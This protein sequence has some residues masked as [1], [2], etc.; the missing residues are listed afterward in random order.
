MVWYSVA[1]TEQKKI[2]GPAFIKEVGERGHTSD[3][4]GGSSR[5]KAEAPNLDMWLHHR[6]PLNPV[7]YGLCYHFALHYSPL[8]V[9]IGRVI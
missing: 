1:T 3:H 9:M 6:T 2:N 7:L 5:I 8:P 4:R